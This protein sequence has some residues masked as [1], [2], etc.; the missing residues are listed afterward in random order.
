MMQLIGYAFFGKN[1]CPIRI[2]ARLLY[3]IKHIN[4]INLKNFFMGNLLYVL[5]VILLIGW[6]LG[7]FAFNAGGFIHALL[8]I[9]VILFL[10][11]LLGGRSSV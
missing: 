9:A 2:M 4:L 10:V 5:A 8:V 1:R 6:L 7:M 3:Y 11:K